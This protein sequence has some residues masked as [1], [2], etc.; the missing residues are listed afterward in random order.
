MV[1]EQRQTSDLITVYFGAKI[2]NPVQWIPLLCIKIIKPANK[3]KNQNAVNTRIIKELK[4]SLIDV[5]RSELW[6]QIESLVPFL[7]DGLG[8][9]TPFQSVFKDCT[10]ILIPVVYFNRFT[11]YLGSHMSIPLSSKI[12][13]HLLS[14][15]HIR[16]STLQIAPQSK[17]STKTAKRPYVYHFQMEPF[18][19]PPP[20]SVN[21]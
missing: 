10:K 19:K 1:A 8:V 13:N 3:R 18:Q 6:Q 5:K 2:N 16:H 9:L 4:N 15:V 11:I 7:C 14:F 12:Y 21:F 20:Q 17:S